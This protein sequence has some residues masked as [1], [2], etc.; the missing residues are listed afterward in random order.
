M[1]AVRLEPDAVA[2][3]IE[4]NFV[5]RKIFS[6]GMSPDE[7]VLGYEEGGLGQLVAVEAVL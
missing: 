5:G 2:E 6:I 3:L 1:G 4:D 7:M